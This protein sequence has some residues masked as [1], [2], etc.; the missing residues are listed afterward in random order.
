MTTVIWVSFNQI[1]DH[2]ST[3]YGR[4][5][6]IQNFLSFTDSWYFCFLYQFLPL[7]R[8]VGDIFVLKHSL[9]LTTLY[10]KTDK[11]SAN[12]FLRNIMSISACANKPSNVRNRHKTMFYSYITACLFLYSL[13]RKVVSRNKSTFKLS[14][15]FCKLLYQMDSALCKDKIWVNNIYNLT[16]MLSWIFVS[17]LYLF[18]ILD[19]L[20][21]WEW[22]YPASGSDYS[23]SCPVRILVW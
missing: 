12:P 19:V 4:K 21:T 16:L 5:N 11:I 15:I 20:N 18:N 23:M 10:H 14:D 7:S 1:Q 8:D 13:V 2:V 17:Y 22:R 9:K 3:R 6:K